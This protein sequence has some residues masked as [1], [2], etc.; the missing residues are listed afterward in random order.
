MKRACVIN[1][2]IQVW[3]LASHLASHLLS[4]LLSIYYA[5]DPVRGTGDTSVVKIGTVSA[6]FKHM[7][8]LKK[9]TRYQAATMKYEE[10][11]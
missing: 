4:Y 2:K 10:E 3:D 1:Q 11:Q 7:C 9:Q 8:L 6:H 5:P